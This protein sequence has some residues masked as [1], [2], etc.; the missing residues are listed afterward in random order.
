M[1]DTL[2]AYHSIFCLAEHLQVLVSADALSASPS[3]RVL[4]E[5][6]L[7][8]MVDLQIIRQR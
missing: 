7:A 6:Y 4:K 3:A 2:P 5:Q 1:A 8:V